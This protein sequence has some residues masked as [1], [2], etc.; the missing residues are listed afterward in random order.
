M[1]ASSFIHVLCTND[2]AFVRVGSALRAVGRIS[3]ND[4]YRKGLRNVLG[5]CKKLRHRFKRFAPIV[6]V[7]S[8]NDH[9]F[10]SVRELFADIHNVWS[11][12]LPFINT[13]DLCVG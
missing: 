12:E 13:D 11:E 1:A 6:L 5:D 4:T 9:A 3:A 8:G 7:E 10:S 2:N